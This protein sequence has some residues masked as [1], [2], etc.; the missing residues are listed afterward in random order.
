MPRPRSKSGEIP[1]VQFYKPRN[2]ACI[3]IE[4]KRHYLGL[5][6]SPEVEEKRLRVWKEYLAKKKVQLNVGETVTVA[7]LIDRFLEDAGQIY[8]KNGRSTG[9]AER[10]AYA[11]RPLLEFY[12]RLPVDEFDAGALKTIRQHMLDTGWRP[13]FVDGTFGD[14]RKYSREYVNDLVE[15]QNENDVNHGFDTAGHGV[16]SAGFREFQQI[17]RLVAPVFT[18]GLDQFRGLR[19]DGNDPIAPVGSFER[20]HGL[21]GVSVQNTENPKPGRNRP[22]RHRFPPRIPSG[23]IGLE[24]FRAWFILS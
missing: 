16:Q 12:A 8:V 2:L 20:C 7:I 4:G 13:T 18:E 10:F 6:G 9:T 11:A 23:D 21:A 17:K 5:W 1:Q 24:L 19:I 15:A 14:L 3:Y 22:G